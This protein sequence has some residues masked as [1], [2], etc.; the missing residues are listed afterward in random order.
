MT[1]TTTTPITSK[2]NRY[3]AFAPRQVLYGAGNKVW[4]VLLLLSMFIPLINILLMIIFFFVGGLKGTS[5][6]QHSDNYTPEQKSGIISYFHKFQT[7]Y[8]VM[9][10]L[11]LLFMGVYARFIGSAISGWGLEMMWGLW[12]MDPAMIE[13]LGGLEWL[14]WLEWLEGLEWLEAFGELIEWA[15]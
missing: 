11:G 7:I 1:D 14:E 5:W 3:S 2:W 15:Q 8:L 13:A 6:I 10:I 9:F 4:W 12:G